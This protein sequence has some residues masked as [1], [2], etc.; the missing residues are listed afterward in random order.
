MDESAVVA[1]P[2]DSAVESSNKGSDTTAVTPVGREGG[3]LWQV[4]SNPFFTAVSN[5]NELVGLV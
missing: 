3:L 1:L 4:S 2:Q 5:R